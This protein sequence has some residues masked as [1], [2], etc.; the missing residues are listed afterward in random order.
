MFMSYS[1][2]EYY[3]WQPDLE[4]LRTVLALFG[5]PDINF[6]FMSYSLIIYYFW[7]PRFWIFKQIPV[8]SMSKT[9][10]VFRRCFAPPNEIDIFG[11]PRHKVYVYV[12]FGY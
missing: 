1:D 7:P 9:Q 8:F 10:F 12:I 3:S 4:A 2:I 5:A 11:F 6:M